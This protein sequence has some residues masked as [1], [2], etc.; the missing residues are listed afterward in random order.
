[1]RIV[2]CFHKI[3]KQNMI[4]S[5]P[6]RAAEVYKHFSTIKLTILAFPQFIQEEHKTAWGQKSQI[7]MWGKNRSTC[8]HVFWDIK[9]KFEF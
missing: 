4:L 1:M 6:H 3:R 9:V 5:K 2:L 7:F 8:S